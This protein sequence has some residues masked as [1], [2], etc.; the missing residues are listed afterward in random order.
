MMQH[1]DNTNNNDSIDNI[2]TTTTTTTTSTTNCN[3]DKNKLIEQIL[4]N[5]IISK[6]RR[7]ITE[8][9]VTC[10]YSTTLH[11]LDTQGFANQ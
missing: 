6:T 4:N 10:V 5:G 8:S 7:T 2:N 3:N 11:V 1:N 9:H